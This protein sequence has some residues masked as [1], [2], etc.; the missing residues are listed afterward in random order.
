MQAKERA[1]LSALASSSLRKHHVVL[2]HDTVGEKK[3]LDELA[4]GVLA[5]LS[6]T[7]AD[8]VEEFTDEEE[9]THEEVGGDSG[10]PENPSE[11]AEA[12]EE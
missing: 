5:L 4:A 3:T 1:R 11:G 7:T 10:G 2:A 9:E 6:E 8:P 12:G